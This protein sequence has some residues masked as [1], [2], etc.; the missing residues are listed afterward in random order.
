[1]TSYNTSICSGKYEVAQLLDWDQ[2]CRE[3]RVKT[4][5]I[6]HPTE[7]NVSTSNVAL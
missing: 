3:L 7:W 6:L 2:K 4:V 5:P 1:M